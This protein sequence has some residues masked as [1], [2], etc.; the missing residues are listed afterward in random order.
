M[1]IAVNTYGRVGPLEQ[2]HVAPISKASAAKLPPALL[3]ALREVRHA[4]AHNEVPVREV[5]AFAYH[6]LFT[7]DPV[8]RERE[9][10][11]IREAL[12]SA[13]HDV[14]RLLAPTSVRRY[15]R[16]VGRAAPRAATKDLPGMQLARSGKQAFHERTF[17]N[18]LDYAKATA[19]RA[20]LRDPSIDLRFFVVMD[21]AGYQTMC[22]RGPTNE[23]AGAQRPVVH[24]MV[25]YPK[26]G[27]W[28]VVSPE[29][30]L[31]KSDLE[32]FELGRALPPRLGPRFRLEDAPFVRGKVLVHAGSY[33]FDSPLIGGAVHPQTLKNIAASGKASTA[34]ADYVC[35]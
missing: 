33:A 26:D 16:A 14:D 7:T 17:L 21:V 6:N 5:Y 8:I 9:Q 1:S 23:P 31:A 15:E 4:A 32:I 12:K 29:M 11:A 27:R 19:Y 34:P 18:C 30:D 13:G 22:P 2:H 35:R 20:A 10:T 24:T 28:W 3:E 25:A